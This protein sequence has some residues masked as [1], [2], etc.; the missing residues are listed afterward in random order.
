MAFDVGA[1]KDH[2]LILDRGTAGVGAAQP[3]LIDID[4]PQLP[5]AAAVV[6]QPLNIAGDPL[7]V[8]EP[9]CLLVEA[10]G[11]LL[12][13]DAGVQTNASSAQVWRVQR[14]GAVWPKTPLLAAVNPLVMPAA[15]V[16]EDAA[17]LLVLDGGLKPFAPTG[18]PFLRKV[19]RHAAVYRVEGAGPPAVT[20]VT[21]F[22]QIVFPTGIALHDGVLY[23]ADRGEEPD[24]AIVPD[25]VSWRQNPHRFGIVIHFV[26]N[27]AI[28]PTVR[29]RRQIA[30]NVQQIAQ[31][32]SPA[33]TAWSMLYAL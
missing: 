30:Y 33:H 20:P 9:L 27:P 23:V 22:K 18:N 3:R 12:V 21:E 14:S 1:R 5:A 6:S 10:N 26:D 25:A 16:R 17:S 11:D 7:P 13:G 15:M 2:L 29:E 32:E 8:V 24:V 19:A 4:V 31:R 28:A